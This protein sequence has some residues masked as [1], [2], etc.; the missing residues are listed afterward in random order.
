MADKP[1]NLSKPQDHFRFA[2]DGAYVRLPGNQETYWNYGETIGY[3]RVDRH[4][5]EMLCTA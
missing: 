2:K 3:V 5:V 1:R 4:P